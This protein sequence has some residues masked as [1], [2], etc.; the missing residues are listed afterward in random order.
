MNTR[1]SDK[2]YLVWSKYVCYDVVPPS[3]TV[4]FDSFHRDKAAANKCAEECFGNNHPFG[5]TKKDLEQPA[6]TYE[7]YSHEI[8][9][10]GL[11][12]FYSSAPDEVW[13]VKVEAVRRGE[14]E[15]N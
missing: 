7:H 15:E 9:K 11:V 8:D 1:S 5:A 14:T 10:D 4:K 12:S 6:G 2:L 3:V 13:E